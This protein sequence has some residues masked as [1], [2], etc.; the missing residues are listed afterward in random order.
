MANSQDKKVTKTIFNTTEESNFILNMTHEG[1]SKIA[2]IGLLTAFFAVPLFTLLPEISTSRFSYTLAAGG[3]AVGGVFCMILALIALIR[4]FVDRRALLPVI[5]FAAMVLWGAISMINGFDFSIGL[6][7]FSGRGE[8]FLALV[9]YFSFFVTAAAIKRD[10]AL[11]TLLNGIIGVGLLNS[12]IALVQIFFGKLSHYKMVYLLI[13]ANAASGL[14]QSPLFLAMVLTLALIAALIGFAMDKS[15]KRRVICLVSAC[16]FSFVMMF[17][18]TFIGFCGLALSVIAAVIAVLRSGAPKSRLLSV[19]AVLVS[20]A[21]AIGLVFTGLIGDL[22]SYK[23]YDGYELWWADSYVRVSA[24]GSF[25]REVLNIDS[26]KDVYLYLNKK[27]MN[28]ISSYGL[29]GTGPDQLS[30]AQIY[31]YGMLDDSADIS[32][33]L[34]YNDGTFDRCYNEYLYTAATRGIPSLIALLAVLLP[35]ICLGYVSMKN[36]R[37]Q[38]TAVIFALTLTGALLFLIGC[39]NVAFSPIFWAA[40]GASCSKLLAETKSDKKAKAEKKEKAQKKAAPAKNS[41]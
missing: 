15:K 5:A 32:D 38:E 27:T 29:T 25:N 40:A 23:L 3:L 19:P 1:Y 16:L 30:L 36:D 31:T 26:T 37:T 12:L 14:S 21:A 33:I 39:T 24:S 20:A 17:T 13:K 28:C 35:A 4:R 41:K 8:G 2:S 10:T 22:T 11:K 18:Y 34:A 6:Y 9:F 7:G